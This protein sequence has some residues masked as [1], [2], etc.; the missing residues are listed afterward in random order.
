MPTKLTDRNGIGKKLKFARETVSEEYTP[1][2]KV[3]KD[4]LGH[5]VSKELS[6]F[7]CEEEAHL[8]I[9]AGSDSTSTV[10]RSYHTLSL[11][12]LAQMQY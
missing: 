11:E 12:P 10:L 4:V 5:F 8:Q 9:L 6:Q 3:E 7:W 1:E 2:T